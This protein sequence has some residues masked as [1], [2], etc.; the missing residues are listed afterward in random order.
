MDRTRNGKA[1]RVLTVI[2]EHTHEC[3]VIKT[4]RWFNSI[5]VPD[6][7]NKHFLERGVP[8]H[9]RLDNGG[10]L[11]PWWYVNGWPQLGSV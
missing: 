11:P 5:D 2:D 10:S 3:L 4:K 9:I 7:L 1:F 8:E 6:C